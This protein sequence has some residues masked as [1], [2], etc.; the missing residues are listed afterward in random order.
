MAL[1]IVGE[2]QS[3]IVDSSANETVTGLTWNT[4]DTIVVLGMTEDNTNSTLG[5]PTATGLTFAAMAGSPSAVAS[6]CKGYAWSAVAGSNGGATIT[7]VSGGGGV[8][9][10]IQAWVLRGGAIGT[11]VLTVSAAKTVALT[12]LGTGSIVLFMGGDWSASADVTVTA[13]PVTNG[14]QRIAETFANYTVFAF[15]WTSQGSPGT[16]PYGVGSA[17]GTGNLTKWAVE[18]IDTTGDPPLLYKSF[19]TA[20]VS[21]SGGTSV[22]PTY[23]TTGITSQGALVAVVGQKPTTANGGTVTT[24]SGWTLQGSLSSAGGYGATLGAD[25]GNTNMFWYTKDTVTGSET[26]TLTITVGDNNNCWAYIVAFGPAWTAGTTPSYSYAFASGSDTSAGNVSATM[27]SDPG[28]SANDVALMAMVIPT[29]VTTPLQFSGEAITATG[30]TFETA[31]EFAEPDVTVGNQSGGW[32]ATSRV[33]TGPSS[34]A[35]TITA[36]ATGTTTNV[37]GPVGVLRVRMSLGGGGTDATVNAVVAAATSA[38]IAPAISATKNPTTVSPVG[39]ATAAA[40]APTVSG[41]SNPTVTAVL[42]LATAAMLVPAVA[43]TVDALVSPPVA[44]ATAAMAAPS[45]SADANPTVSPP[46]ASASAALLAPA[47]SAGAVVVAPTAAA[48]AQMLAPSVTV[49]PTVTSPAATASGLMLA[50]TVS[51][52]AVVTVPVATASAGMLAPAVSA[53]MSPAVVSPVAQATALMIAPFVS[54]GGSVTIGPPAA[55]ASAA[56]LA[57]VVVGQQ[58]GSVTAVVA[59]AAAAMITPA[60]SATS[61][62]TL[63]PPTAVVTAQMLAPLVTAGSVVVVEA[64]AATATAAMLVP[65]VSGSA[66]VEA[67]TASAT[68]LLLPPSVTVISNPTVEVPVLT[69]TAQMRAPRVGSDSGEPNPARSLYAPRLLRQFTPL[70]EEAIVLQGSVKCGLVAGNVQVV[71]VTDNDFLDYTVFWDAFLQPSETITA[72]E[73]QVPAE[74]TLDTDS[75]TD[76]YATAWLTGGIPAHGYDIVNRVTTSLGEEKEFSFRLV[77]QDSQ[78][79][80]I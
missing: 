13:D 52:S 61:N 17:S 69:A 68:A 47:V 26:G 19:G 43:A 23:P 49:S 63:S 56:M 60:V 38:A 42:A 35:P 7:S 59:S 5:T 57:P 20:G 40:R 64:P 78:W 15:D 11:P 80:A 34:A 73:W 55:T 24:P 14:T 74:I 33:L 36:T 70:P 41:T 53:T 66:L 39:A 48:S 12:R 21:T 6:S 8:G 4:G 75:F 3:L 46:A 30:A 27:G 29:D 44:S 58:H 77:I 22:A 76:T 79:D 51:G 31:A 37:R 28:F 1:S 62:A 9:H 65:A 2:G 67:P 54:A 72:S 10:G 50:P 45:V 32:L 71:K 16:T 18:Y 25:T